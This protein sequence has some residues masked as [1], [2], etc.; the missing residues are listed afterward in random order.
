VIDTKAKHIVQPLVEKSADKA[1][2]AG[3]HANQVTVIGF[4]IGLAA[5]VSVYFGYYWTGLLLLWVSGFIDTVDGAMA[6]KTT[7]SKFGT[8]LDVSFDRLVEIG[9]IL[10]LAFR[11]PDTMWAMLLLTASILYTVTI[12]LTVGAVSDEN[13][14]KSFYYQPALAERTEGFLLLSLMI[15]FV[16]YLLFF[17]LLFLFVEI[18]TAMQRLYHAKQILDK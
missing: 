16:D 17:T 8:V 12:F 14:E 11:F 9:I 15:I 6:R 7:P 5:A 18:I 3:M 4:L 2:R 13:T 10:A 1:L